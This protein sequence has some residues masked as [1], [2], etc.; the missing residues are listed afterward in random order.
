[1]EVKAIRELD[2]AN[3]ALDQYSEENDPFFDCII[4]AGEMA[5]ENSSDDEKLAAINAHEE[6]KQ[7]YQ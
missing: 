4:A 2:L 5:D 1:M 7:E 6:C 3:T